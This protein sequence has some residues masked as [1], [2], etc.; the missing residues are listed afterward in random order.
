M[1]TDLTHV[2]STAS[3]DDGVVELLLINVFELRVLG[4]DGEVPEDL[5]HAGLVHRHL[6]LPEDGSLGAGPGDE[7]EFGTL[8]LLITGG[9][10]QIGEL[11]GVLLEVRGEVAQTTLAGS[12]EHDLVTS[13]GV[14][15][16]HAPGSWVTVGTD[17]GVGFSETGVGNVGHSGW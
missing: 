13:R 15:A 14:I 1:A 7:D 12:L 5:L 16:S 6:G 9:D 17:S 8:G 4:L 2:V 11:A 3:L 10:A